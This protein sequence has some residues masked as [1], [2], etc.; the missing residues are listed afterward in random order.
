MGHRSQRHCDRQPL[1]FGSRAESSL[2]SPA[3]TGCAAGSVA[4]TRHGNRWVYTRVQHN[5]TGGG[6]WV[7]GRVGGG[8]VRACVR[9]ADG[10]LDACLSR[11]TP[12]DAPNSESDSRR[13]RH[14]GPQRP[15]GR[16]PKKC[17]T[18]A[19]HPHRRHHAGQTRPAMHSCNCVY[20]SLM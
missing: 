18:A 8:G 16:R 10:R 2:P 1:V 6:R 19:N 12:A 4:F 14:P 13:P 9:G 20:L 15:D 7:R 11:Y 5:K 3:D 17:K